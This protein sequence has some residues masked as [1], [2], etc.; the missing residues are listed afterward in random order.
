MKP[1]DSVTVLQAAQIDRKITRMAYEM[2]ER[3]FTGPGL[4]VA[5][6]GGQGFVLAQRLAAVLREISALEVDVLEVA[7]NK[8]MPETP[9]PEVRPAGYK[10]RKRPVILVDDVLNTGKTLMF[11]LQPFLT[12]GVPRIETAVLVKRNHSRFPVFPQYIGYDLATTLNDH[13]RVV[14]GKESTVFLE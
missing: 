1:P 11:A 5:G 10:F 2:Y 14:L 8:E 4:V 12:A 3:H 9:A 13:V 6:I 7:I